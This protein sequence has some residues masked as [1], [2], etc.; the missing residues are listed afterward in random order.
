MKRKKLK[1]TDK[2]VTDYLE[3]IVKQRQKVL[4][5][6]PAQQRQLSSRIMNGVHC[7]LSP[8]KP[9]LTEIHFPP[10][11][12]TFFTSFLPA[13]DDVHTFRR[14]MITPVTAVISI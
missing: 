8:S 10:Q 11:S 4:R 3:G 14:C 6:Q 2:T 5:L 13:R 12:V 1:N 7:P 9:G